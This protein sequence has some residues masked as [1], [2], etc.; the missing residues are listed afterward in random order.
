MTEE[1]K[2]NKGMGWRP[3]IPDF[4]DL[5]F[6]D[7]N[8]RAAATADLKPEAELAPA[9]LIPRDRLPPVYDQGNLGSCVG[10][11]I[12][13]MMSYTRR[14]VPRS[15]L[16]I[17]YEARRLINET[18]NDAGC[19]IRDGIKVITNLGAPRE[20]Y[21]PYIEEKVFEDPWE[22]ADR[23]AAKRKIFLYARL[24]TREDF[25]NCIAEGYPFTIGFAVYNSF[26]SRTASK[27]GI[28]PLPKSGEYMQG[29]HAVLVI[30]YNSNFK[31][32][33]W[34]QEAMAAGVP[35]ADIPND[36][37]YVRNS[38]GEDWGRQGDFVIDARYL[39][40]TNLAADA[41]TIRNR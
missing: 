7:Q 24:N 32:T 37:Y 1:V 12:S 31:G 35:E 28:Q 20:R 23:D 34:A 2:T 29:G 25:R 26:G 22:M 41:W 19:Y 18:Q 16:F 11:A 4:R 13:T 36:V 3:D 8:F 14:V 6:T 10:N 15:R 33:Q 38:W 27:H 5:N 17:Y 21:W 40:S 39:E 9:L 30:G